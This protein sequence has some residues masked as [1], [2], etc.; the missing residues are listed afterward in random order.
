MPKTLRGFDLTREEKGKVDYELRHYSET[1]EKAQKEIED[2]EYYYI[3]TSSFDRVSVSPTN[4]INRTTELVA[5]KISEEREERDLCRFKIAAIHRGI[6][7]AANTARIDLADG[8][9]KDLEANMIYKT[10]HVKGTSKMYRRPRHELA[11]SPKTLQKYRR[12]AYYYI[13][14]ELGILARRQ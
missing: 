2:E 1:E 9:K 6:S 8:L 4:D 11:R 5:L 12:M 14:E 3:P 13:A 10:M 7:R